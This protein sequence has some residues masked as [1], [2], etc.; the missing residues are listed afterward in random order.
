MR[1]YN[2][3]KDEL[4]D[5]RGRGESVAQWEAQIGEIIKW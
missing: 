1:D 2:Q 3:V 5:L 4:S